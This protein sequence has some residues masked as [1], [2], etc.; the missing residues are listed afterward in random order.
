M[1]NEIVFTGQDGYVET[2]ELENGNTRLVDCSGGAGPLFR[3]EW[4]E[5]DTPQHTAFYS[6]PEAEAN[7]QRRA[8]GE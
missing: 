1:L 2:V 3:L 4:Q 6:W 5:G 7:F 8:A